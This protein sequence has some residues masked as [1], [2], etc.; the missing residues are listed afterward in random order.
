MEKVMYL[1]WGDGPV[2]AD[3]ATAL[4]AG[5]FVSVGLHDGDAVHA[6]SPAPAAPGERTHVAF[7]GAW[8]DCYQRREEADA[9]VAAFG[10]PWDAY[11]VVE[12]LYEDYA[13]PPTPGQRSAGVLTVALIHRPAALDEPTWLHNWH[14]VQSPRS[15]ELQP[16]CRYVRNR[17]VQRLTDGAPPIDGIVEEA[18]PSTKVVADPMLFFNTGGDPEALGPMVTEM[19]ANVEA[20]LDL[21]RLRSTTMSEYL[22]QP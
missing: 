6:P 11:L 20:C 5:P 18:W 3:A 21:A 19:L 1:F 10:L 4:R 13:T 15:G 2:D 17:V 7:A 8:V 16:R 14:E 22:L 12:S 9:A